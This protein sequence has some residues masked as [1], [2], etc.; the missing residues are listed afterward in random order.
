MRWTSQNIS[1]RSLINDIK[2]GDYDLEPSH[3]RNGG[4]HNEQWQKD[5]VNSVFELG[6]I[7]STIWHTRDG[8]IES[9]D[10]KQRI[11]TLMKYREDK[12]KWNGKYYCELSK[13]QQRHFDKQ[14]ITLSICEDT[15]TDKQISTLF[16]KLQ[17]VKKTAAGEVLNSNIASPIKRKVDELLREN[18]E[19]LEALFEYDEKTNFEENDKRK[20]NSD[21]LFQLLYIYHYSNKNIE[22]TKI[23]KFLNDEKRNEDYNDYVFDKAF[24]LLRIIIRMFKE[25]YNVNNM[26]LTNDDKKLKPFKQQYKKTTIGPFVIFLKDAYK[27]DDIEEFRK[28]YEFAINNMETIIMSWGQIDGQHDAS[29]KRCDKILK[30]YRQ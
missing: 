25:S 12:F 10:G 17:V 24:E 13:E 2:A 5:L 28:R 6:M 15:L 30:L 29:N 7:P 4:V 26:L 27:S 18:Q 3:Q 11:T 9:I 21:M 16:S 14:Q 22:A 23:E 20:D 8:I 19:I 1:I